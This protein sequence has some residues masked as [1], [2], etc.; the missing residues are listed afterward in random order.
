MSIKKS[1]FIFSLAIMLT[2][3]SCFET[4]PKS[5]V[6]FST[7]DEVAKAISTNASKVA[8]LDVNPESVRNEKGV[9]PNAIQLSSY[10]SYEL[11]E[12]PNDKKT[13]LIFYC[14]NESCGASTQAANR[15]IE[16]GWNN[17]SIMREGIIGWNNLYK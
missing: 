12:L 5:G 15:A 6:N 8:V 4:S 7:V 16:N 10:N 13:E 1:L 14:Y 9:I 3:C 11:K 17:V 2:S